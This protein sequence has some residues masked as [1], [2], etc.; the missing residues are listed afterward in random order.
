LLGLKTR[1]GDSLCP[2]LVETDVNYGLA[3]D[4]VNGSSLYQERNSKVFEA[5]ARII[6]EEIIKIPRTFGDIVIG[7]VDNLTGK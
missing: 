3:A 5:I 1:C 7:L 4:V 2:N 6:F